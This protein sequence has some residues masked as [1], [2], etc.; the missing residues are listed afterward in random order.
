MLHHREAAERFHQKVLLPFGLGELD[1]VRVPAG[2]VAQPARAIILARRIQTRGRA[3]TR[4][5]LGVPRG[6]ERL[7]SHE[8]WDWTI[9]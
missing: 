2:G 3:A 6:V 5:S 8:Q 7:A 4:G 1:G 9:G